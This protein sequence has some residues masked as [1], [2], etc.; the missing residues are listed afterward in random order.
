VPQP[1]ADQTMQQLSQQLGFER[2]LRQV[3]SKIHNTLD[4]DALLQGV[5][6]DLGKTLNVNRCLIVRTDGLTP[7][8][9][10]HEYGEPEM[11]PLG[12]GRTN[13]LPQS[14]INHFQHG[15]AAFVEL[16]NLSELKGIT[17]E[18]IQA[19]SDYGVSAI[20][21]GPLT[22][23]GRSF[24]VIIVLQR[25]LPKRWSVT[26]LEMLAVVALEAAVALNHCES[27]SQVKDQLFNMNLVGNLI[28][29]LTNTLELVA[30]NIRT[31]SHEEKLKQS[32]GTTPLS[33]RE[34][35]VLKLIASGYANREIAK[36]LF[37]TES[38]V[39]LHASR[40]RKKLKLKSRTA[41]VKYACDNA[42]V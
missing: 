23:Q 11:S 25:A 34:L 5:V 38:T 9:I 7:M 19:L 1:H 33:Y 28:Q 36:R 35:E 13:Q 14:V 3:I 40:I 32:E 26:E 31:E 4:R 39:E 22:S 12:L 20:A 41:L 24:G 2:W 8:V 42:L 27:F 30:K 18:D 16:A 10:T 6:D 37:L 29:Q 15:V 17:Q 21:G